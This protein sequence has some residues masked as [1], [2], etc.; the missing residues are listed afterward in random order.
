MGKQETDSIQSSVRKLNSKRFQFVTAASIVLLQLELIARVQIRG[1]KPRSIVMSKLNP[2]SKEVI[3]KKEFEM[4]QREGMIDYCRELGA[5]DNLITRCM[6]W[7]VN[8]VR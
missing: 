4:S 5:D 6:T 8:I 2:E 1:P 3:E 7:V